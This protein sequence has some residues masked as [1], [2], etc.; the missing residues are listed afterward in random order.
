M[1]Q[2]SALVTLRPNL[3]S[4]RLSWRQPIRET[5]S[6]PRLRLPRGSPSRKLI[7]QPKEVAGIALYLASDEAAFVTG[8][9][10]AV[11]GGFT[12]I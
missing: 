2:F 8:Q 3:E 1:A 5:R 4:T 7:G 10:M 9:V 11:D 6:V 12:A